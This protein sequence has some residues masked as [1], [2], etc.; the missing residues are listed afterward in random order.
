MERNTT[1]RKRGKYDM[2][3]LYPLKKKDEDEDDIQK[4]PKV[5]QK[6]PKQIAKKARHIPEGS[7]V[8]AASSSDNDS[9]GTKKK[10]K[11]AKEAEM[12]GKDGSK[13]RTA[14]LHKMIGAD[15]KRAPGRGGTAD[16]DR[17]AAL[18][19]QQDPKPFDELMA[20]I[21]QWEVKPNPSDFA[22]FPF[23]VM[24]CADYEWLVRGVLNL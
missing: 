15:D 19:L 2:T 8:D 11:E 6:L 22:V 3:V 7:K 1:S 24:K 10:K 14:D 17:R 20:D 21:T 23:E 13:Y 5:K 4:M 16:I 18:M 12:K 9:D